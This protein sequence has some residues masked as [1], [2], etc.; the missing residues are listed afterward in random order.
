MPRRSA[1]VAEGA[2]DRCSRGIFNPPRDRAGLAAQEAAS[3]LRSPVDTGE[4]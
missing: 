4:H 3:A 1:A 2:G